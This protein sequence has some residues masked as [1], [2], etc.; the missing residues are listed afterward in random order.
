MKLNMYPKVNLRNWPSVKVAESQKVFD[1]GFN[2]PNN[3]LNTN[4]EHLIKWI[5][6]RIQDSDLAHLWG[7]SQFRRFA[8]GHL[9][10]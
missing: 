4:P 1:N 5:E 7:D 8:F 6:L 9:H 3:G 2:L 10:I